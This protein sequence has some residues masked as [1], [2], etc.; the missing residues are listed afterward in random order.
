[1]SR[2]VVVCFGNLCRSPMAEGLLRQLLP[3]HEISS[4]GTHAF[5]GEPPT[6]TAQEVM[7]E[8]AGIDISEQRSMLL[9]VGVVTEADHVFT[10]SVAQARLAAALTPSARPRIRLLG[11]FAPALEAAEG[12]ADP[13]GETADVIE[14]VDPMGGSYEE[15]L[16]CY[17]RLQRAA[18]RVAAWIDGGADTD[19][20]PPSLASPDWAST[21]GA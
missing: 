2:I 21:A 20:A 6:P 17:V 3:D 4:A 13:G 18:E 14:I 5:A 12:T 16:E 15:Y 10:M 19:S 1:M 11:A 8:E 9:T 7:L